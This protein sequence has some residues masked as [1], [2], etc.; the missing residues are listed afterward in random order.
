MYLSFLSIILTLISCWE[1][2][3]TSPEPNDANLKLKKIIQSDKNYSLYK[4]ENS[5]I[6][7]I[8]FIKN[9]TVDG[10]VRMY[11]DGAGKIIKN[12]SL[13]YRQFSIP[14]YSTYEYDANGKI[15]KANDYNKNSNDTY[16]LT[17]SATFEYDTFGRV[18]KSIRNSGNNTQNFS[19]TL[20]YDS[21]GNIIEIRSFRDGQLIALETYEYDSGL[22]PLKSVAPDAI[23]SAKAMSK[24]NITKDT[25]VSYSSGVKDE[26][27][28]HYSYE[29]NSKNYPVKCYSG[30]LKIYGN[31]GINSDGYFEYE[32]Y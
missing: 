1:T 16:E 27:T 2:Q 26:I 5:K 11:Y 20:S 12:E 21:R 18:I 23:L 4:Y 17:S 7:S 22:N 3:T 25:Y 9:D 29:Y 14:G 15:I 10:S 28:T 24:N 19:C 31:Q 32:Y 13:S 30:S 6:A 8:D